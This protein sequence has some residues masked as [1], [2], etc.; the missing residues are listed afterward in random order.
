MQNFFVAASDTFNT[1]LFTFKHPFA[2]LLKGY[3]S[4]AK[5]SSID[6]ANHDRLATSGSLQRMA[7]DVE[8][9]QPNLAAELRYFASKS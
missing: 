3:G 1:F 9:S 4:S 7:R 5:S 6:Q 2:V 8:Y